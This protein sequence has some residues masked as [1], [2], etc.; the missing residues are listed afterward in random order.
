VLDRLAPNAR[1]QGVVGLV[2]AKAYVEPAEI[3]AHARERQEAPLVL[4][5]DQVQDPH[6]LGA[7]VRSAEAAGA[8]GV[9]VPERRSVGLTGVVAKASAGAIEH[10]RI[11]RVTNLSRTV[12]WLQQEALW[13][14]A[15]DPAG[16]QPYTS[17]DLR[18]GVALV[19]GGEGRGVRPGVREKCDARLK[20]PMA[21]RLASLNLSAAAA[22]VLFE[23]V[24]QRRLPETERR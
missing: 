7:V 15:L 20:I 1:H 5:L 2:D 22:I 16:S 8:H 9:I 24:R 17:V 19:L 13:V 21:G 6:N 18:G 14:Y 3:L 11:A 4:I 23:A 12:E 10:L